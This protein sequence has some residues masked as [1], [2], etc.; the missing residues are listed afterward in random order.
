MFGKVTIKDPYNTMGTPAKSSMP[1]SVADGNL[2]GVPVADIARRHGLTL[3]AAAS[4][5]DSWNEACRYEGKP[6]GRR[7][8]IDL[9]DI[10]ADSKNWKSW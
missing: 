4:F 3:E 2:E 9:D 8:A 10:T 7:A 6:R 1:A 5:R